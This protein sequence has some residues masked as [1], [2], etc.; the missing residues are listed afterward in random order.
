MAGRACRDFFTLQT[1]HHNFNQ[2]Q[3][4]F[5]SLMTFKSGTT[6]KNGLILAQPFIVRSSIAVKAFVREMKNILDSNILLSKTML[7]FFLKL[8]KR[9]PEP[10]NEVIPQNVNQA[11]TVKNG[12]V[13]PNFANF[14]RKGSTGS[15]FLLIGK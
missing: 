7:P 5:Y 8:L 12:T 1:N 15:F 6:L 13:S 3:E 10:Q 4:K 14:G 2:F 11:S 9:I